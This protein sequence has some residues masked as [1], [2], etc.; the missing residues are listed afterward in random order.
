[1]TPAWDHIDPHRASFG[2]P[3]ITFSDS[4]GRLIQIDDNRGPIL[5]SDIAS[6]PETPDDE[7]YIFRFDQ[8]AHFWDRYPTE[9]GRGFTAED[10]AVNINRQIAAVDANGEPDALF[11]RASFYQQTSSVDVTDEMTLVLKTDGPNATYLETVHMGYSFITSPE[12]IE[13]WDLT[14][15]DEHS[16]VEHISGTGP[17]I[18]TE[19]DEN[20]RF[21]L[22]R[23]ADYWKSLEGQQM[24]F[25]DS[26][27]WNVFAEP[28]ALETAYR[29]GEIDHTTWAVLNHAQIDGIHAD[30]PDH[31]RYDRGAVLPFGMRFNYNTELAD[32]P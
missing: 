30:F 29:N 12:A 22:E 11:A 9:G 25:F 31:N 3:F 27:T 21:Q 10:A 7:T 13:L 2:I 19:L 20:L 14:W 23:N 8:G 1:M 18:P 17:F 6:L 15:R 5:A 32:N 4:L 28:V 24:P 26:I 16:N